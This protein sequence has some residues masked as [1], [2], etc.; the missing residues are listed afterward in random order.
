MPMTDS[1]AQAQVAAIYRYPVKGLGPEPLERTELA[2]GKTIACDRA[3]AIENGP[4]GFDPAQTSYL[5]KQR[6]LMLMRNERLA[7]LRTTF[8]EVSHTLALTSDGGEAARVVWHRETERELERG[9]PLVLMTMKS[10]A[11]PPGVDEDAD[12]DRE[13]EQGERDR[14]QHAAPWSAWHADQARRAEQKKEWTPAAFHLER[15]Y[16][17]VPFD[18]AV[19]ARLV[20]ALHQIPDS[21]ASR[22]VYG[23]LLAFDQARQAAAVTSMA[24]PLSCLTA[25]PTLVVTASPVSRPVPQPSAPPQPP[26]M[27]HAD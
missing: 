22:Q 19:R 3:Y 1:G 24:L 2:P 4:S 12:D 27:S 5:P 21:P 11:P 20:A 9:G 25:L 16:R 7:A 8:D 10:G 13:S 14:R 23:R 18:D 15:L 26:R 17:L 6:F